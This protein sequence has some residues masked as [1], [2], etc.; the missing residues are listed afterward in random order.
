M[1]GLARNDDML[2]AF[3]VF[4]KIEDPIEICVTCLLERWHGVGSACDAHMRTSVFVK[5]SDRQTK[6]SEKGDR[7]NNIT[8][9]FRTTK[10]N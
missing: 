6:R 4:E 2:R 3:D 8:M 5:K 1:C 7:V 10:Q 9:R